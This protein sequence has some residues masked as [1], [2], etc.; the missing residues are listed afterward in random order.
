MM[1]ATSRPIVM[2]LVA[3]LALGLT[4]AESAPAR[5]PFSSVHSRSGS[6]AKP[7]F[8]AQPEP[9][10][11]KRSSSPVLSLMLPPL[12]TPL[13]QLAKMAEARSSRWGEISS[14]SR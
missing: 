6:V 7:R 4:A 11:I 10:S 12:P 3:L 14:D 2:A 5:H 13:G 8:N 9:S 1:V